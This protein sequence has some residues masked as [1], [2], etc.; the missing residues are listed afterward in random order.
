MYIYICILLYFALWA[1]VHFLSLHKKQR[2]GNVATRRSRRINR[3]CFPLFVFS[4][5]VFSALRSG[6]FSTRLLEPFHHLFSFLPVFFFFNIF[7]FLMYL[8][9]L[10][11]A[12]TTSWT[13][14]E[15]EHRLIFLSISLRHLC[16]SL[17]SV[18]CDLL[19]TRVRTFSPQLTL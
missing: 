3:S 11:T 13:T 12:A 18:P 10:F 6:C 5:S 2:P 1:F 9:V 17:G 19:S 4:T 8:L 14:T 15:F 16:S 7:R